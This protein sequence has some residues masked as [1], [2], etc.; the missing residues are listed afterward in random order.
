MKL[1]RDVLA[2]AQIPIA[3]RVVFVDSVEDGKFEFLLQ[4]RVML[5]ITCSGSRS[6]DDGDRRTG[7]FRRLGGGRGGRG[8]S[9]GGRRF[10]GGS[11]GGDDNVRISVRV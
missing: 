4:R 1:P 10:G 6:R 9:R 5:T 8:G 11:R 7:G 3:A 2:P